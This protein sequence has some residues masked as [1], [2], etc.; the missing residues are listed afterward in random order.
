MMSI[1]QGGGVNRILERDIILKFFQRV[2]SFT[3]WA[4]AAVENGRAVAP[5][6]E[7]EIRASP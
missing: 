7:S 2:Y 1:R 6:F 3:L 5:I 4:V